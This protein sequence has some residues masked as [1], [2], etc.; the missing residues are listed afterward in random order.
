ML[1]T[2]C[3]HQT[4]SNTVIALQSYSPATNV[5]SYKRLFMVPPPLPRPTDTLYT[6]VPSYTPPLPRHP[7]TF[8]TLV[9]Y[10]NATALYDFALP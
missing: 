9:Q 4:A 1:L 8:Y 10:Q 2:E 6:S 5:F 3:Y 7:P